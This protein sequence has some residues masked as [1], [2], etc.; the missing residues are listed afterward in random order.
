[1]SEPNELLESLGA[2]ER[3]YDEAFPHVW[4]DV[5]RGGRTT[6]EALADREG[7]DDEAELRALAAVLRPLGAEERE[8]WVERVAVR[9][10]GPEEPSDPTSSSEPKDPA[11]V[12]SLEPRQRARPRARMLWLQAA[13][14]SVAA[15]VLVLLVLPPRDE[16]AGESKAVEGAGEPTA[17]EGPK[18]QEV[19]DAAG[20][21]ETAAL[22]PFELVVRNEIVRGSRSAP[23][24][25]ARY[26]PSSRVHWL[27]RPER[28]VAPPL[29]LRIVADTWSPESPPLR[30][31]RLIDPGTIEVSPWGVIE[32]QGELGEMLPLGRWSLRMLVARPDALPADPLEFDAGGAWVV[33]EPYEI[34]VIP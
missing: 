32:L 18:T 1:M 14:A 23:E 31:R 19:S 30:R 13:G 11:T 6:A 9:L 24:A 28:P 4:E 10:G 8:A 12:V 17:A 26:H 21:S 2:L 34:E 5:V 29:G 33:S 15:A 25:V 27:I 3:E 22:P 20:A 7:I 16:G